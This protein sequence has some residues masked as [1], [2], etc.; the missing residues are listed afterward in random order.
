MSQRLL[1]VSV[2]L[3]SLLALIVCYRIGTHQIVVGSEEGGWSFRYLQPFRLS[4]FG[5]FLIASLACG[6][7]LAAEHAIAGR[8]EWRQVLL[9]IVIALGVQALLRSLT[10]Y[11]FEQ[12]FVS[13][14]ANSFYWVTRHYFAD[15][16]LADFDR[17]RSNFPLHAQSNMPGK[18]MIVYALRY[19]ATRP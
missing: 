13:E 12:I 18:L 10:P 14:G 7:L 8:G 2:L 11:S 3:G 17:V 5:V 9:W 15:T 16:V 6:G 4:M 19:I 1:W